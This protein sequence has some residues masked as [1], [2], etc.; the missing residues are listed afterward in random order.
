M[1][2]NEEKTVSFPADGKGKKGSKGQKPQK[3]GKSI[4]WFFG[5][6]ILI[7]ICITFV[8]PTTMFSSNNGRIVFGKY[9]GKDI[10]LDYDSYFYYQAQ[11]VADYYAQ[12]YGG[13]VP[14]DAWMSIYYIAFQNA[15]VF[16]AISELA[17]Q[18]KIQ[19]SQEA[20]SETIVASGYWND[21]N[22]LFDAERYQAA[23]DAEKA[24]ITNYARMMVPFQ[25]VTA[26]VYG[27]QVSE[28]ETEFVASLS[29]NTR[30]FEYYIIDN[31]D[32]GDAEAITYAKNNPAPFAVAELSLLSYATPEEASEVL[33]R[34]DAGETDFATESA[35]SI[36]NYAEVQGA[37]GPVPK[38]HLDAILAYEEEGTSDALFSSEVGTIAGPF[39][40]DAG[41]SLFRLESA[42]TVPDF[43]SETTL[44]SIKDYIDANDNA[45][46]I[47][48][49]GNVAREVYEE[50]KVDFDAAGENH[51]LTMYSV[52]S[53]AENPSN[54][55]LILS[56]NYSDYM[57]YLAAAIAADSEYSEK[58]FSAEDNE[59]LEPILASN[60]TYVVARPVESTP[61]SEYMITLVKDMYGS[62]SG[63]FS[64]NDLENSILM[65]D[66]FE[67]N[68]LATYLQTM[69]VSSTA[70]A[71]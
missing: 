61:A 31:D 55:E 32:Y 24:S 7:F 28:A 41:Y 48:Y 37:M 45:I 47:S 64:L 21:E 5:M 23:T 71:E 46:L 9:D 63:Q 59:V 54:S 30:D 60:S 49:I 27:A 22:G 15:A 19:P 16:E 4:G 51:N 13:T 50:A 56:M 18:A 1:P 17:D 43:T 52:L 3:Y 10:A 68:F 69:T 40:T 14:A 36:D 11:N 25:M 58:L 33:A 34:L 8:L 53:A 29:A 39:L 67:D 66:K 42:P 38:Y 70:S 2:S 35:T 6:A 62:S 12:Q 26:D 65:S 20:I 57:G 44:A